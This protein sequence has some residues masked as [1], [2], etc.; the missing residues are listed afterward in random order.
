M[1]KLLLTLCVSIALCGS[2]FAQARYTTH[3][4]DFDPYLHAFNVGLNAYIQID[5]EFVTSA[6]YE[7]MEVAA[8]DATGECRGAQFL[9]D[10]TDLGDLY[11]G[12]QMQV[13]YDVADEPL[14]FELWDHAQNVGYTI[15]NPYNLTTNEPYEIV[16]GE[17]HLETW[18]GENE[19]VLAF[20]SSTTSGI[21]L[22]LNV[23]QWYLISSPVGTVGVANVNAMRDNTYD[24]YYFNQAPEIVDG[25]G[26]EWINYRPEDAATNP[27]FEPQFTELVAG[28]GYLYANSGDGEQTTVTL[29]FPGSAYE[30]E[31]VSVTLD[32]ST[33]N[34]DRN[35]WGWNL[36][37]NPFNA[38]GAIELPFYRMIEGVLMP[39]VC[40]GAIEPMEGVFVKADEDGQTVTFA[41]YQN[42][43]RPML[44][45]NLGN[46][47]GTIDRAIVGFG[48][49]RTLPIPRLKLVTKTA[50]TVQ[51]LK[52]TLT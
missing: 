22:T 52:T 34:P 6:N 47:R 36:V 18:D 5:G 13:Y 23:N 19:V 21:D 29:T 31:E 3:W 44:A 17:W 48:E 1:K 14:T 38:Q 40:T 2:L 32:R 4:E 9:I 49:G 43:K 24:L 45:L 41:P 37:G 51:A 35:M 12:I 8:F 39:D 25:I 15:C 50:L 27:E 26:L 42:S 11:P 46:S 10:E 30:G 16:T 33:D 28:Q 7:Q 20:T